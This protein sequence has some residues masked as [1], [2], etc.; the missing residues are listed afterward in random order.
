MC[1]KLFN[2]AP[3]DSLEQCDNMGLMKK[4]LLPPD[5]Y[6]Y[7]AKES[8][9]E[10]IVCG[11]SYF[12]RLKESFLGAKKSIYI[13]GWSLN[14][15]TIMDANGTTLE[16]V[17]FSLPET[18][19]IKILIWDYII[20]YIPDRDPFMALH[21][22]VKNK[23]NIQFER[24]DFHPVMSSMHAKM[25]IVDEETLFLG[26]I[27]IDLERRDGEY[28][29]AN[30]PERQ[31]KGGQKYQPFRDYALKFQGDSAVFFTGLF[32]QLWK[33]QLAQRSE[34]V[35][36][37]VSHEDSNVFFTRTIPKFKDNPK[38]VSSFKMH[39]WLIA[40]AKKYIYIENQYLT[41]DKIVDALV[42]RLSEVDGPE[43]VIVVSYGKMPIIEKVSMGALLT[44][45]VKALLKSDPHKRLKVY[46]LVSSGENVSEYVKVHSK[47]MLVDDYFLKIGSSNI[48]NR[49]MEFDY[50]LDAVVMGAEVAE[51]KRQIFSTLLTHGE[52][53]EL[54][55]DDSVI[56]TFEAAKKRY[57][58][59]VEVKDILREESAIAEY[60][61][62]LPLDKS[63]MTFFERMGQT[64]IQKSVLEK[65][66]LK[67]MGGAVLLV[68]I[69]VGAAVVDPEE[70]K[71]ALD[72]VIVWLNISN[73]LA[74]MAVFFFGYLI[75]GSFF[76]PL[77]AYIFLCGAYF[78]MFE[79]FGL[80]VGGALGSA[81]LSYGVG[82]FFKSEIEA[83]SKIEKIN[84]LRRLLKRNSLKTLIFLRMVPVAPFP[85]VNLVCGKL[86]VGFWKYFLG[87]ALG[88]A[89]GSF[90]LIFLEQR[91]IDL[92]KAPD[93]GSIIVFVLI[94]IAGFFGLNFVKKRLSA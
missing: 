82:A 9:P 21:L 35:S 61:D 66:N 80:A 53:C 79:A 85:L 94:L 33:S 74:L 81:T 42:Q 1:V 22:A 2:P 70:A 83:D 76:F 46:T 8:A 64:F 72:E 41:S 62:Y 40:N 24:F 23:K 31:E 59:L 56:R 28:N 5:T 91:L 77:N 69:L 20:F 18:V 7:S 73:G 6:F 75:L 54:E 51:Y 14:L 38:D 86:G 88:V 32:K 71:S 90:V 45:S 16:D 52:D 29:L 36:E 26:G 15:K 4:Q 65:I 19:E 87:T 92:I 47:C 34:F 58:K 63:Q 84:Q 57:G 78:G 48:N 37:T 44:E 89:P 11:K 27:D 25:A 12:K 30:D 60:K 10:L 43:V 93:A 13:C 67:M 50:E 3:F 39:S 17:L 68:L 49:S 55:M